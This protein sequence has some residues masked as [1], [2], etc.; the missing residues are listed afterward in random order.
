MRGTTPSREVIIQ[1]GSPLFSGASSEPGPGG[2]LA[3]A[4]SRDAVRIQEGQ[5]AL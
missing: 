4:C 3:D 5:V 2:Y 1:T